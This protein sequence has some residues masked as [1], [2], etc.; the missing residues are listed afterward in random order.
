MSEPPATSEPPAM[1]EPPA[2]SE[3]RRR[4]EL[5]VAAERS[6]GNLRL[7]GAALVAACAVWIAASEPSALG[8]VA[9]VLTALAAAGW[10]AAWRHGRRRARRAEDWYLELGDEALLLAE[11][12]ERLQVPWTD[13]HEVQVD[14]DRLVVRLERRNDKPL[15]IQPRYEGAGLHELG[16]AV[17]LAHRDA[18]GPE[19]D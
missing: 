2:M 7:V 1:R 16:E 15:E 14:E 9:A 10:V 3:P 12:P 4:F 8:W 11:G 19:G 5:D 6:T 17:R 18:S 13:V